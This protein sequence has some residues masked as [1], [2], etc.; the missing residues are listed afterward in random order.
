MKFL[1]FVAVAL[2]ALFAF[3]MGIPEPEPVAAASPG[4]V[5]GLGWSPLGVGVLP[6]AVV[7]G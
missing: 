6:G 3:A 4:G 1:L 2:M 5:V 7:V